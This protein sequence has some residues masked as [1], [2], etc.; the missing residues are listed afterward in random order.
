MIN[1]IFNHQEGCSYYHNVVN[2]NKTSNVTKSSTRTLRE[3]QGEME[4]ST[5]KQNA[6]DY[7]SNNDGYRPMKLI[8][9]SP[10]WG[11]ILKGRATKH[12]ISVN[13][14]SPLRVISSQ[15]ILHKSDGFWGCCP[16]QGKRVLEM[17]ECHFTDIAEGDNWDLYLVGTWISP[18]QAVHEYF[19]LPQNIITAGIGRN[20]CYNNG[21]YYV[22]T[23]KAGSIISDLNKFVR[24]LLEDNEVKYKYRYHHVHVD[25][26]MDQI[27][28]RET[29]RSRKVNNEKLRA[30]RKKNM[31]TLS[32]DGEDIVVSQQ[33]Q[34]ESSVATEETESTDRETRQSI[35]SKVGNSNGTPSAI[36]RTISHDDASI[37]SHHS[38]F[39]NGCELAYRDHKFIGSAYWSPITLPNIN[40][41]LSSCSIGEHALSFVP[42]VYNHYN[43]EMYCYPGKPIAY[44]ENLQPAHAYP[45][46]HPSMMHQP[47]PFPALHSPSSHVAH[48]HMHPTVTMFSDHPLSQIQFFSNSSL[49]QQATG[50]STKSS[51]NFSCMNGNS[52]PL[53]ASWTSGNSFNDITSGKDFALDYVAPTM[54]APSS[55]PPTS[56]L[57]NPSSSLEESNSTVEEL[58]ILSPSEL[59]L[60]TKNE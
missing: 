50:L 35:S 42:G 28:D 14:S 29:P 44:A 10:Y 2:E 30:D 13:N 43:R 18:A 49:E 22:G 21:W 19:F 4:S 31:M 1:A 26:M 38:L 32:V 55:S 52:H 40:H 24:R 45:Y 7:C 3:S 54:N 60:S 15:A 59:L 46:F 9:R 25:V 34:Q 57:L 20:E 5:A 23:C 47:L 39:P 53:F 48:E 12:V 41:Y 51:D 33:Q 16:H 6:K 58:H 17:Q 8:V 11:R 27:H 36:P 56:S 37:F